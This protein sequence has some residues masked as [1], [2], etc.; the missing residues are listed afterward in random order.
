MLCPATLVAVLI[1]FA[2]TLEVYACLCFASAGCHKLHVLCYRI[3]SPMAPHSS[4]NAL[5][6]P[7]R[8]KVSAYCRAG[9]KL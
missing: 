7:L 8:L 9:I 6:L 2:V 3:I 4:G 5:E 1:A